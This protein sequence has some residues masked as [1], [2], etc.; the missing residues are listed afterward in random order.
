MSRKKSALDPGDDPSQSIP[1]D[2][3]AYCTGDLQPLASWLVGKVLTLE[4]YRK[5]RSSSIQ[6]VDDASSVII[7]NLV[8]VS[9]TRFRRHRVRC[10]ME[11]EVHHGAKAVYTGVQ[12]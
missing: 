8:N 6:K 10:F 7:K 9:C 12:A 11:Q 4:G 1:F 5:A 3:E 2:Y